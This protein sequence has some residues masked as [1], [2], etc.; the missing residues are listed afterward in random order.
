MP[1]FI[2]AKE[3]L[4][5]EQYDNLKQKEDTSKNTYLYILSYESKSIYVNEIGEYDLNNAEEN[6]LLRQ[7][8]LELEN[9]LDSI[10]KVVIEW[11]L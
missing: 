5:K 6:E 9:I 4:N 11:V 7:E 8:I 2:P 3:V 1:K 10:N